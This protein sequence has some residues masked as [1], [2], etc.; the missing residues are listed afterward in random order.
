MSP[1]RKSKRKS[2]SAPAAARGLGLNAPGADRKVSLG[3]KH[4]C[5]ACSAKFYDMNRPEVVCPKCGEDQKKRPKETKAASRS[6]A[7]SDAARMTPLLEEEE[8]TATSTTSIDEEEMSELGL[9]SL[10]EEE[11]LGAGDARD[12][13]DSADEDVEEI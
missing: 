12:E 11:G 5:F 6:A 7:K 8:D 9:G 2:T 13:D 4:T 1:A 10:D 3:G